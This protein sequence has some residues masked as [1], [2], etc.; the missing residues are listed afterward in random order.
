MM[1]NS[2]L[3]EPA[4]ILGAARA[5]VPELR[6]RLAATESLR[7][8][9]DSTVAAA[10]DAGL[11]GLLVPRSLGGAGGGVEEFVEQARILAH[12][13]LSAAWTLTFFTAHAWMAA[14]YP[15]SARAELFRDGEVP[16]VTFVGRPPGTAVPTDG[17]YLVSGSWGYATGV[18]N[19][20]WVQVPAIIEGDEEITLFLVER[21]HVDVQDS[22]YMAGMQ[23][24]GSQTISM[25]G[26]FVPRARTRLFDS[27]NYRPRPAEVEHPEPV[28]SDAIGDLF[29]FIFPALAVGGA[30][31]VLDAYRE[32][33]D[34]HRAA[35][36]PELSGD[37]EAGQLRYARA[38]SALRVARTMLRQAVQ[39]SVAVNAARPDSKSAE[40]RALLK[41]DC[42]SVCRAAWEAV[43]LVRRG[44]GSAIFRSDDPTQ[45]Y[46]RDLQTLLSHVTIDEDGMQ[47]KAG[48]IL[49]GRATDPD[50]AKFFV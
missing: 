42:L 39:D 20:G 28:H 31:A 29:V 49:L 9:P 50:P 41:L 22:W 6:Q 34:R 10:V 32:R 2:G 37:T 25:A 33:L 36:R 43:E 40:T 38:L 27:F 5:M 46:L 15:R 45:H 26:Q 21:D 47:A 18:M 12:G 4:E 48:Q 24:T 13:D 14:R 11:F 7:R 16:R 44:S 17:G 19:A 3:R 23:G 1:T 30:E 8:L 35:F